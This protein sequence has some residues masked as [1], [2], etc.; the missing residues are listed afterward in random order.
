MGGWVYEGGAVVMKIA[1]CAGNESPEIV[2]AIDAVVSGL[3][4]DRPD[5]IGETDKI[6]IGGLSIDREEECMGCYKS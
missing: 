3:E 2:D 6:V 4:N 1:I 5:G